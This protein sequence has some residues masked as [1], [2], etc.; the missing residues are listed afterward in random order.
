MGLAKVKETADK[1]G[2]KRPNSRAPVRNTA[3]EKTFLECWDRTGSHPTKGTAGM[4]M[5]IGVQGGCNAG[6]NCPH[7]HDKSI[8][9]SATE[10][11]ACAEEM[12]ERY[13]YNDGKQPPQRARSATPGPKGGS[14]KGKQVVRASDGKEICRAW[15]REQAGDGEPCQRNPCQFAHYH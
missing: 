11:K 10:K 5:C 12:K 4:C 13:A 2:G 14:G 9:F 8:P 6:D 7:S 3:A 1:S 15:L